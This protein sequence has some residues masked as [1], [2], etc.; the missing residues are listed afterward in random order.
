MTVLLPENFNVSTSHFGYVGFGRVLL[1][2]A[3]V[4]CEH[5]HE[6]E[7]EQEHEQQPERELTHQRLSTMDWAACPLAKNVIKMSKKNLMSMS[8]AHELA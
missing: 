7:H 1:V 6:H 5:E 3:S 4:F 8:H 2:R